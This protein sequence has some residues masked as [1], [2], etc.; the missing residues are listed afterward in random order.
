MPE[1]LN[2]IKFKDI[3]TVASWDLARIHEEYRKKVNANA[4][5]TLEDCGAE[6]P[7][8]ALNDFPAL[9]AINNGKFKFIVG[10]DFHIID[11]VLDTVSKSGGF[12]CVQEE[13]LKIYDMVKKDDVQCQ[14]AHPL[15]VTSL[16]GSGMGEDMG[17]EE[18]SYD[19]GLGHRMAQASQQLIKIAYENPELRSALLPIILKG[20]TTV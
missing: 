1:T 7:H 5:R 18:S 16:G 14:K 3:R 4:L 19:D 20:A 9:A 13:G 11:D 6:N 12:F 8:N 10:A 15:R 17:E 2:Q